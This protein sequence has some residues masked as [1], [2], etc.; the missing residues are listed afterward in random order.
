MESQQ[1]CVAGQNQIGP[2]MH[3]NLQKL[4]VARIAAGADRRWNRDERCE[5]AELSSISLRR[6]RV[7]NESNLRRWKTVS[8]S[9]NVAVETNTT[10]ERAALATA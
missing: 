8:T 7:K 9:A 1:V 3:R 5:Y 4:V 2:A 10:E 6:A